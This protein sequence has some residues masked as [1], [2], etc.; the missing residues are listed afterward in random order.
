MRLARAALVLA[1]LLALAMPAVASEVTIAGWA[2]YGFI[3]PVNAADVVKHAVY[4][5]LYA[6]YKVD[7]FNT[8]TLQY[9]NNDPVIVNAI[10]ATATTTIADN[11]YIYYAYLTTNLAKFLKLDA[12]GL[13]LS[14]VTG[15][16]WQGD[17]GYGNVTQSSWEDTSVTAAGAPS[18]GV[19]ANISYKTFFTVE[20]ADIPVTANDYYVGV[21]TAQ[22]GDFGAINAELSYDGNA[23]ATIADGVFAFG[24]N[25]SKA[26]GDITPKVGVGMNY[27]LGTNA[28]A[29][30]AGFRVTHKTLGLVSV[31]AKGVTGTMFNLLIADFAVNAIKNM[32]ILGTVKLDFTA[33]ADVFN[34]LDA[35]VRFD[36]GAADFYLGYQLGQSALWAPTT[37][38]TTATDRAAHS[39]PYFKID[40][41]SV[42]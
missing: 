34:T 16:L 41:K 35:A 4:A 3:Y 13:G 25:W 40:R 39:G 17:A 31:A 1:V 27:N 28:L 19:A 5:R 22:S 15:K 26:F 37:F 23:A 20:L 36:V 21:Y 24:A 30:N 2:R 11:V 32:A 7:D 14:L 18:W 33:G 8:F 6:T 9:F 10:G 12:S 38:T 29:W 42:V